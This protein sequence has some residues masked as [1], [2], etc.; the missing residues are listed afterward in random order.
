MSE[1]FEALTIAHDR[2][3]EKLVEREVEREEPLEA[4]PKRVVFSHRKLR[5]G[6]ILA[7]LR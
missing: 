4:L 5:N 7:F 1:I 2:A 6:L 3:V